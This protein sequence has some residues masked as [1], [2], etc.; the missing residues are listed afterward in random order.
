MKKW[1]KVCKTFL[2][3]IGIS[4]FFAISATATNTGHKLRVLIPL[5]NDYGFV[6]YENETFSG[7]YIDYFTEISKYTGW[8]YEFVAVE[9]YEELQKECEE[10]NFDFITGIVYSEEYDKNYFEYSKNTIGAKKYV[11]GVSKNTKLTYDSE[12]AFLRGAKI[13]IANNSS[14]GELEMRFRSF[15][16]MYGI[17]CKEDQ[18]DYQEGVSFI[19]IDPSSRQE[20]IDSGEIDGI[21]CSDAFCLSQ[22]MYA[23]AAFGLDH[24]YFVAPNGETE[25]IDELDQVLT[26]INNF[27]E[28]FSNRLYDKYFASNQEFTVTFNADEE[29]ILQK[30]RSL[31]VGLL[32]NY[33]PYSYINSEGNI[34]GMI[35]YMLNLISEQTEGKLQFEYVIYGSVEEIAEN[36]QNNLCDISG[37]SL[38]SL[39]LNDGIEVRRSNSFYS[40]FFCYYVNDN[41]GLNRENANLYIP[42]YPPSVLESLEITSKVTYSESIQEC[43]KLAAENK[44]SYSVLLNKVGSYYKSYFGLDELDST[45]VP[46]GEVMLC[47]AYSPNLDWKIVSVLDKCLMSIPEKTLTEYV[48]Q[49][50]LYD[51][52]EHGLKEFFEENLALFAF[53]LAGILLL[54]CALLTTIIYNMKRHSKE[55]HDLLYKDDVTGGMSYKKFLLEAEEKCSQ[56]TKMMMLYINISS[57]KYVNDMFGFERGNDVLRELNRYMLE[58]HPDVLCARVYADRFVVLKPYDDEQTLEDLLRKESNEFDERCKVKFPSFNIWIKAG[59]YLVKKGDTMQKAVNFANY[60]VDELGKV[61]KS[62]FIFFDEAMHD[63]VLVQKEIEIDMWDAMDRGE[64]EAYYQPK[65]NIATKELFG[66]EALVRWNHSKKGLLSPGLFIPIFE[67]NQFIIQIDFYIFESVCKFLQQRKQE[68]KKLF[69]ISSNFSRCHLNQTDFV[70]RLNDIVLKYDIPHEFLEIE[71]TETVAVEDFDLLIDIVKQLKNY[72]FHVSIDDFGSGHSSIQ[73]LYKL[74]IDVVKFDKNFVDNNEISE[75]EKELVDSIITVSHNNGIKIIC[76]GVET[77]EQENFVRSH[78]CMLVQGFL[79]AKPMP[80]AEFVDLLESKE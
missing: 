24:I 23:I 50:S 59:V 19:H 36:V 73:L 42:M 20:M 40:D 1:K 39:L 5:M 9:S 49:I 76:E 53:V 51:H 64:F 78:H 61:S 58:K 22:D 69:T 17:E 55:V 54:L 65:Y 60:A 25:L 56:S 67:K 72:G 30:E 62:E 28:D 57:F 14:G 31:T 75:L 41:A 35:P 68:G 16:S 34:S 71:I 46:N 47:L 18:K 80:E 26:K 32:K 15:C 10:G 27:D 44:N 79:Y 37:I 8:K 6:S 2:V 12:Y 77:K 43:M 52:T 70:E 38:Y 7:Y 66:A 45:A 11:F 21:L 63:R 33:A 48:T 3:S 13:G 29:A 4:L 74:P